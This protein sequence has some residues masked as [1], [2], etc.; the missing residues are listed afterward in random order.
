MY[1][2]TAHI[3]TKSITTTQR[4][5]RRGFNV[6][7]HCYVDNAK[8][9]FESF[10]RFFNSRNC[11]ISFGTEP[12]NPSDPTSGPHT[13]SIAISLHSYLFYEMIKVAFMLKCTPRNH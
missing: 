2:R 5:Y 10:L 13:S 4:R 1:M 8:H 6:D 9:N 11:Y 3:E 7:R 12:P